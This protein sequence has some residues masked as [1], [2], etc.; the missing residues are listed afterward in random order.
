MLGREAY[1]LHASCVEALCL[2]EHISFC[3]MPFFPLFSFR[4][5]NINGSGAMCKH[6]C[7]RDVH[8][9]VAPPGPVEQ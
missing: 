1:R 5:M 8:G 9:A 4:G 3:R 7:T 6:S 2:Q